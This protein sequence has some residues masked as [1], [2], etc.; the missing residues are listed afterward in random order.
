MTDGFPETP[1]TV[2]EEPRVTNGCSVGV[3]VE[4]IVE[5]TGEDSIILGQEDKSILICAWNPVHSTVLATACADSIARIWNV[6]LDATPSTAIQ[7]KVLLHPP[8]NSSQQEVT[9][10]RWSPQGDILATGSYDG[11]TRIW[12]T[13]GLLRSTLPPHHGPVTTLKWNKSADTLLSLSCDG[14]I[15]AWDAITGDMRRIFGQSNEE[16]TDMDWVGDSQFAICGS[17]G[18]VC[19]YDLEHDVPLSTLSGHSKEVNCV[20]WD[21]GSDRLASGGVDGV[22]LVRPSLPTFFPTAG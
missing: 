18:S 20:V 6:P 3:Q 21:E 7:N 8:C 12:T 10:I 17:E 14:K 1:V 5:I 9:A 13:D 16:A 4:D 22:V 15:I 2:V 11:Q 19:I